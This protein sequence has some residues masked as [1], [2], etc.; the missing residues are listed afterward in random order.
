MGSQNIQESH[1]GVVMGE[2][3]FGLSGISDKEG[4]W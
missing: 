1:T 4:F 3:Q 2:A